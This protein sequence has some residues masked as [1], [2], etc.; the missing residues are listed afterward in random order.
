MDDIFPRFCFPAN[1]MWPDSQETQ[2]LLRRAE[3][4]DAVAINN[5]MDRHR[6]SL[7][8]MVNVRMDRAI[9]GRV[10]AS[11]V[12]QDVLW[13]A[14]RRLEDYIRQPNMPFHLW[15]RQLAK[16]RM[17]DMH[18]RHRGAKRRSVD[19][20]NPLQAAPN[21]DASGFD[22]G[23][24]LPDGE[25]TP[26]A[27]NIRRELEQRFLAALSEL[28]EDDRD[29]LLMRHYEHLGNGEVATALNITPAAAGM[30]HLR[31]LKKLRAIL[32]D[33]PSVS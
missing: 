9:A 17:I 1:V 4:G 19:R 15:L 6:D 31:A 24:Q 11:D 3:E 20:E 25:L 7:R 16:D 27:A 14:S 2:E 13:E 10:D 22:W 23:G 21:A 8:Q 12:V 30:R 33:S 26:A 18:R 5:L 32:G 28:E 29:I